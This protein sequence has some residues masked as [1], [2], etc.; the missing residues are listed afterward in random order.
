MMEKM[1]ID[2]TD[3]KVYNPTKVMYRNAKDLGIDGELPKEIEVVGK[4]RTAKFKLYLSDKS[5]GGRYKS[6]ETDYQL[7]ILTERNEQ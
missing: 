5:I 1:I 6:D 2:I 4:E 3:L 7:T